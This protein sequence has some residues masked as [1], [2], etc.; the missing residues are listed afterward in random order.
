MP[1]EQD[2]M[3]GGGMAKIHVCVRGNYL[4][5]FICNLA[6]RRVNRQ[7]NAKLCTPHHGH[8]LVFWFPGLLTFADFR[9]HIAITKSLVKCSQNQ[10][11]FGSEI[12]KTN[13]RN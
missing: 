8:F 9:H 10:S 2:K 13:A 4:L 7:T 11:E 12:P 6:G 1:N 5:T 3:M